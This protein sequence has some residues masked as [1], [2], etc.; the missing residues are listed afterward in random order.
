MNRNRSAA[1]L[2]GAGATALALAALVR[3]VPLGWPGDE[4]FGLL[5]GIGVGCLF[6]GLLVRVLP[7]SCETGTP[8]QRRRYLREFLPPMLAYVV[9]VLGSSWLLGRIDGPGWLRG[10]VALSPVLPIALAVRAIARHIRTIDELQQRIELEALSIATAL[11]TL[12]YLAAGFLQKARVIDVSAA[13]AMIWVFPLVCLVYG[14]AKA[15][16]SRRY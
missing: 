14:V 5:C 4:G 16:V 15:M 9:V 2:L 8:A 10:L 3:F 1:W 12:L 7:E 13:A 6:A 11:V